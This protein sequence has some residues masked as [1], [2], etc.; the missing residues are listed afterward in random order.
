MRVHQTYRVCLSALREGGM[1]RDQVDDAC[2]SSP[3][4]RCAPLRS[5]LGPRVCFNRCTA[6]QKCMMMYRVMLGVG[7]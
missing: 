4:R 5:V 3:R 6:E 7:W 1:Q 2:Y